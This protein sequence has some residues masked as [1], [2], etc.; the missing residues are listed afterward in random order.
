MCT[1]RKLHSNWRSP[2]HTPSLSPT[3]VA[4]LCVRHLRHFLF[5][6]FVCEP[7]CSWGEAFMN[8]VSTVQWTLSASHISK[9]LHT[10][11]VRICEWKKGLFH[12]ASGVV[13]IRIAIWS[14]CNMSIWYDGKTGDI[15][16]VCQVNRQCAGFLKNCGLISHREEIIASPKC[17][18]RLSGP[19]VTPIQW[20]SGA[21][22]P[23]VQQP[24]CKAH[25][26]HI[27]LRWMNG[28]PSPLTSRWN[29]IH[30]SS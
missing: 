6:K 3:V 21:L 12:S 9:L 7:I 1:E 8:R 16:P 19:S 2:T 29:C 14:P 26:S 20:V 11:A 15:S 22:S 17:L 4:G 18:D 30:C 5:G 25:H 24:W 27:V 10:S 23:R 28:A 13:A